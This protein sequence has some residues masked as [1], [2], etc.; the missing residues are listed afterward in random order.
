MT[1][2]VVTQDGAKVKDLAVDEVTLPGVLG[3]LSILPGHKPMIIALGIG[4]MV[5]RGPF[6]ERWFS[7]SGGFVEVLGDQVRVLSETCEAA[8]EVDGDRAKA[9]LEEVTTRMASMHPGMGEAWKAAEA[10]L[11]KAETRLR[12]AATRSASTLH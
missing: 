9:H 6:G 3:E 1:I 12:V 11:K 8:E 7:L 2:E 4:P 10:S 5:L